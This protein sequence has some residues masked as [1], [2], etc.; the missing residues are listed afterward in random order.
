MAAKVLQEGIPFLG[1][2]RAAGS[3][4]TDAELSKVTPQ[5]LAALASQGILEIEGLALPGRPGTG[6]GLTDEQDER[7][8]RIEASLEGLHDKI[9]KLPVQIAKV[10][11]AAVASITGQ[12]PV[13]SKKK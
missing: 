12:P 10:F 6:G 2:K 8:K 1:K 4:I 7:L 11:D 9:G 3:V 13:K 5:M